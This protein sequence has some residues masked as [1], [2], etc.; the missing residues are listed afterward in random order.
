MNKTTI[1]I[2]ATLGAVAL[3]LGGYWLGR[4]H[5]AEP[6]AAGSPAPAGAGGAA[7]A[8]ATTGAP[9]KPGDVDPATGRK[10]LYW[11]DPMVPGQR[12]DKPGKSPFM[13]MMLEPVYADGGGDAST[14]TINPRVQQNIG[15]RV[16]SATRA[17]LA[18]PLT[19]VGSVA[20]NERDQAV[21]QA[22]A[23][24]F[25]EKL[26]VRAPLDPV[27]KGQPLLELYVPD[28]VAAQEEYLAVRRMKGAGMDALADGARQRMRLAGMSDEQIE[29][30]VASGTLKPRITIVAP[31]GGVV[32][33][34]AVREGM[35]VAMG[36]PLY[37]LNGL[38]SVW[39]NA[40]LP[41]SEA[42]R[43]R[44]GMPVEVRTASQPDTVYKGRVGA[45]LPE[46]NAQTR[47][48]R[49]RIEV[50]NASGRLVPGLYASVEFVP[51]NAPEMT[52]VPSEAVIATGK[53]TVVFVA[54]G[55][56]KFRPVDV[57][58]GTEAN[59]MTEIRTGIEPGQKVVVS[60]QFL[61]DSD[62][63]LKG[64]VTRLSEAP[65]AAAPTGAIPAPAAVTGEHRGEGRVEAIA[66]DEIMLS[67]GPIAS[68]KWG[69]MTM[70]F[71][72]PAAGWPASVKV[73]DRVSFTF[74]PKGAGEFEIVS[75]TP[76]GA[77][78]AAVVPAAKDPHAGHAPAAGAKP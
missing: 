46:I 27:R 53:R 69:P 43:V 77:A 78:A 64:T 18:A 8:V 14:V 9:Q 25:V 37:R 54:E 60:G 19:A 28:W 21:V 4:N 56:G 66:K 30:V 36:T 33:E 17:R 6:Q 52:V 2:I 32:T 63:S 47:T 41:E 5:P 11:H 75:V 70:G 73:G 49:A 65:S 31:I 57:T 45:L 26:F 61:I 35:T 40:E 71:V 15:V 29:E 72:P 10:V 24:G 7:P 16:A 48:I 74:R 38:G 67:H 58:I 3:G 34:L 55:D 62:A 22:R 76:A 39:I 50:A 42:A 68:L 12:F 1:T 23:N 51:A 44:T 59:G 13:N 20:F